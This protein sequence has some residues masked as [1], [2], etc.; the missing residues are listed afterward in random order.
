[1]RNIEKTSAEIL[2]YSLDNSNVYVDVYFKDENFWLTQKSM[3]EL[4]DCSSDNISLQLKNIYD[5]D[6]LEKDSTTEKFS[7]VRKEGNRN[8]TRNLE[9]YNSL[10]AAMT[11][12]KIAILPKHFTDLSRTSCIL[13]LPV[14]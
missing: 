2:F 12:I 7:V 10:D 14:K 13:R 9:F 3:A 1:M 4:F 5:E 11:M 6:E 8:V